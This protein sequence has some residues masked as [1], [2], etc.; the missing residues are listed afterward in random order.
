MYY[1]AH[2]PCIDA[3]K[4]TGATYIIWC[5]G[6][7]KGGERSTPQ[8]KTLLFADPTG[9]ASWDFVSYEDAAQV[10]VSA[11]ETS[12]FDNKHISALSPAAK[13]A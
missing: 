8:P 4:A 7:M 1:K 13:A 2:T 9:L 10:M 11:A 5:P 12:E 6:I 3:V